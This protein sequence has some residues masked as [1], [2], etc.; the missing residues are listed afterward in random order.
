MDRETYEKL[1][2]E[3]ILKTY[4]KTDKKKVRAINIDAKK[5]AKDLELEDRIE[6]MQ[7]S[8]CYI[9]V[10]DHKEDVP[11]KISCRLINPSKSDIG[12]LSKIIIDRTIGDVLSSVQVNQWKNSQ[13]VIE[14]FK[15]IRN[16]NNASFIVFDIESFYPSISLD[17][18]HK[19][20]NFVKTICDIPEKDI[21]II[22]QSRT[23]LLFNNKEPWLKKSGN[24]EFDVPMGCFDGAEVCEL[25][26]VYIL[27][28][29]KT[30]KRKENV[31]LYRDD[32][33]GVLRN[34]S[35]PEIE[36]KRKQII[37]IFKSCGLNIT[38]RTNLKSVDFLD[39]RLDL[40]NNMY[41]SYRK[42][43]SETVYINKHSN[44]P[45]DISKDQPKAINK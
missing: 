21:S 12:K 8:E 31:G 2:H 3:N 10:K 29:L 17:L 4:K 6:K 11:R 43:N 14:W 5:I 38:I 30:V 1:S 28:L 20:I 36:R 7:E 32:R 39:V 25:V 19:A 40:I 27:H 24:E 22:I 34:S 37:Q 44:H 45:S 13:T 42:P 15:N 41:Q 35:G 33:L 9:I 26:G 23:T 16:K 18:F